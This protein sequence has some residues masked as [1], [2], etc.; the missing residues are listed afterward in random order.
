ML[1]WRSPSAAASI[2]GKVSLGV[3]YE[4][5]QRFYTH[6]QKL[7]LAFFDSQQTG[8]LMSRA[9]VDLQ[10]IRFF[11]G[12]GLIFITQN[13]LTIGLAAV[14]MFVIN[15]AL[16]ALALAPVP[17]LIYTAT[18]YN[19]RNRPALQEVQQRIGELTSAAEESVS[20]IR[21]VKAFAREQHM[22]QRFRGSVARVFDQ[23]MFTTRLQAFYSPLMGL[24]PQHRHGAGAL[25]RRPRGDQRQPH[26]RRLHCLLW[27][28]AD[29]L[30]AGADA[31]GRARH[32]AAG[33]RLGQ[34]PVP[35]AR[36]RAAARPA[37][38]GRRRCRPGGGHVELRDVTLRYPETALAAA[39]PTRVDGIARD[40]ALTGVSL[41][42]AAGRTVALVGPTGSGKTSL[43][44][45]LARLYDPTEGEVLID[46]AD[47]RSVDLAS[48]RGDIAY[49]S[50]DS[51]LFSD[52][53]AANIAY[54]DFG[55]ER[56]RDRGGG[57]AGAG[58]RLHHLAARGL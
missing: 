19:R 36:P 21:I 54:P 42:V 52:T 33:D 11:L 27:L 53:V 7:E 39:G 22:M 2:A 25:R 28:P 44:A 37:R 3:E 51:F 41:Q 24:P 20:G 16:A 45:L 48:L 50:D 55:A 26:P 32:V 35:G 30:R 4:L 5:R 43:V 8:Q 57:A 31:R 40:A 46:G 14:V 1:R 9:T 10:A 6:L 17:F 18:R 15:P 13:M 34:P 12:Y 23:S 58:A 47:V 56:E 49:V 29:A 38:R